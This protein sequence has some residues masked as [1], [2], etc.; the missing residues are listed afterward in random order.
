MNK[1]TEGLK[2]ESFEEFSKTSKLY[3]DD[4]L[5]LSS[6]VIHT[7]AAGLSLE[8]TKKKMNQLYAQNGK[9]FDAASF[10]KLSSLK[11]VRD[12][13]DALANKS[14][15]LQSSNTVGQAKAQ[16]KEEQKKVEKPKEVEVDFSAF[17]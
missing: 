4:T 2:E 3:E 10:D 13:E 1:E 5:A 14:L 16:A 6:L 7:I 12:L 11:F 15:A 8:S 9:V 17:F